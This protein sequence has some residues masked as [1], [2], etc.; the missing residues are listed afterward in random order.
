DL[1]RPRS[2]PSSRHRLLRTR[3]LDGGERGMRF[4]MGR[5]KPASAK[6][7]PRRARHRFP[8]P[9]RRGLAV[10]GAVLVLGGGTVAAWHV[11]RSGEI[12]RAFVAGTARLGL[13]VGNIEVIGRHM[14]SREAVL[15]AVGAE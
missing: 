1:P 8:L 7:A 6:A 9:S 11:E 3:P 2:R 13:A 14:T 4:L 10:I 12:G 5:R 15:R